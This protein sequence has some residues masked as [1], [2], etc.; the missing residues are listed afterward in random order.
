METTIRAERATRIAVAMM[1]TCGYD[2]KTNTQNFP[3][4][5]IVAEMAV[6]L[7][8]RLELQLQAP[9]VGLTPLTKTDLIDLIKNQKTKTTKK[10]KK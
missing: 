6:R 8:D 1:S 9:A 5:P 3:P 7:A 10:T 2:P 4:I